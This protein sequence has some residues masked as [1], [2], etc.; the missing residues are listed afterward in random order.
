MLHLVIVQAKSSMNAGCS[1]A[2]LFG[3]TLVGCGASKA[4]DPTTPRQ[5]ERA[6]SETMFGMPLEAEAKK[7]SYKGHGEFAPKSDATVVESQSIDIPDDERAEPS[8]PE[9]SVVNQPPEHWAYPAE[10]GSEQIRP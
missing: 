9:S 3:L 7:Q 8:S 10:Q 2:I 6:E 5:I 1:G 4:T